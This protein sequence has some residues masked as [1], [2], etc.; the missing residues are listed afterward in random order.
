MGLVVCIPTPVLAVGPGMPAQG[1]PE[2]ASK[3]GAGTKP[4]GLPQAAGAGRFVGAAM[5]LFQRLCRAG[6]QWRCCG[7]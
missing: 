5:L 1:S 3:A 7:G 4:D 6:Q 2:A